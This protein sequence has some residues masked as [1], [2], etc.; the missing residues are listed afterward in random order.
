MRFRTMLSLA[1]F[2]LACFTIAVFAQSLPAK[3][4]QLR[5]SLRAGES[6][7]IRTDRY[8]R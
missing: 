3:C 4:G 8:G 2:F 6:I 5:A 7:R 1:T